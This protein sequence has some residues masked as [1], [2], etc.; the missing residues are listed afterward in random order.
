MTQ[1]HDPATWYTPCWTHISPMNMI[2]LCMDVKLCLNYG[3]ISAIKIIIIRGTINYLPISDRFLY[4]SKNF[5]QTINL[6]L[7]KFAATY[8]HSPLIS[9]NNAVKTSVF[10]TSSSSGKNV[11][12]FDLGSWYKRKVKHLYQNRI[13]KTIYYSDYLSESLL[14]KTWNEIQL[15]SKSSLKSVV[16]NRL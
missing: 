8:L 13:W 2:S 12:L 9:L 4:T 16:R 5:S 15:H 11:S 7:Q 3:G 1:T 14:A 10:K 6:S